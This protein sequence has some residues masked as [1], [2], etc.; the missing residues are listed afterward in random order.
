MPAVS[1]DNDTLLVLEGIGIPRWSARALT[2][3]FTIIDAANGVTRTINGRGVNWSQTQFRKYNL[4]ITCLDQRIAA[5]DGIWPG[6]EVWIDCVTELAYPVYN[7]PGRMVV[8]DSERQEGDFIFYRPR[9]NCL[10]LGFS[11][12]TPEWE[13]RAGWEANFTEI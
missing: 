11:G 5:F 2:E 8:D 3:R 9:L 7:S 1:V 4:T 10:F 13:G 12:D 6:A